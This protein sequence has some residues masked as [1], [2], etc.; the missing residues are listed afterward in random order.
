M[1]IAV[2]GATGALGTLVIDGLL[3]RA[4][5]SQQAPAGSQQVPADSIVAIARSSD[6][7]QRLRDLGVGVRIAD[8]DDPTTLRSALVGV[9]KLLLISSNALQGR[10]TQHKAV[11][12]AAVEAGVQ[13]IVYTSILHAHATSNPLA[14]DHERTEDHIRA[15]GLVHTFLRNGWYHEN[16]LPTLAQAKETG[17]ILSSAA[18][19]KVASASRGDFAAAAVA[20]LTG[21]GHEGAAYELAGDTA[22]TMADLARTFTEILGSPVALQPVDGDEHRRILGSAGLD[23][24]MAA[25]VAAI[26]AAIAR[27][28]LEDGSGD[29]ARLIGRP[30]TPLAQSLQPPQA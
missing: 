1:T 11:V 9:Q 5:A 26:D 14:P 25:F 22:W 24:G 20:V 12:D 18:D 6:K 21:D 30:T 3:Q 23:A 10:L 13:H 4:A 19:G 17:A 27:G 8:Y 7:A 16:Y 28:D 2:T 15:S 29:L